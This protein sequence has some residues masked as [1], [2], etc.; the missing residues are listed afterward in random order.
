MP[1]HRLYYHITWVTSGRQPMI[2]PQIVK[3]VYAAIRDKAES[4]RAKVFA[5]GGTEDHVHLAVSLPPTI[6]L[7]DFVA[8]VKG[9]SAYHINHVPGGEHRIQWQRGYGVLSFSCDHLSRVVQ[10]VNSQTQHHAEKKLWPSLED[11]GEDRQ[12]KQMKVRESRT[13]YDPFA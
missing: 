4:L 6:A 9:A 8:S 11:S 7:S 3:A 2:V 13:E 5:I 10:Y 12:E 1:F